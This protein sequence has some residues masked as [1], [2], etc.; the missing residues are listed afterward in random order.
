MHTSSIRIWDLP[1]RLFH[2]ALVICVVAVVVSAKV[3]AFD[4]HFR[5]GYGVLTLLSF[6]LVWGLIGGRWSRFS[7]FLFS[8]ASFMRYVRGGHAEPHAGHSPLGALSVFA[9]LTLLI[10]QV[11]SGL[12]SDDEIFNAGPLTRFVSGDLVSQATKYHAELGQYLMYAMVGL[13]VLAIVIYVLRGK[14]LV[15]P[16]FHGNQEV[17]STIAPSRDDAASRIAALVVFGLCA[18]LTWWIST[19]AQA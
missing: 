15:R 16:M 6:R 14:N 19:L 18:G 11:G 17:P 5:F 2:W 10:V 4:W 9:L 8:P 1:T 7:S 13:H 3:D 12:V